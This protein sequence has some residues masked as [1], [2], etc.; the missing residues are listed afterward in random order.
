MCT[1][2]AFTYRGCLKWHVKVEPVTICFTR[3]FSLDIINPRLYCAQKIVN[4]H[5][6]KSGRF[7]K[8]DDACPICFSEI[9]QATREA[10]KKNKE[11]P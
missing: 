9:E 10:G 6:E 4:G 11:A 1:V 7:P 3:R 5:P 8:I 2:N